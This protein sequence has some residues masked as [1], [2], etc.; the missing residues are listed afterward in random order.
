MCLGELSPT[1]LHLLQ[2]MIQEV[3]QWN[4]NTQAGKLGGKKDGGIRRGRGS[5][6]CYMVDY[7]IVT[8]SIQL[9]I[10]K[11]KERK[12]ERREK[13]KRKKKKEKKKKKKR[14]MDVTAIFSSNHDNK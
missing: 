1:G 7:I 2:I 13:K 12:K 5:K 3:L 8:F 4:D 14:G 10:K 11:K 6:E 9:G